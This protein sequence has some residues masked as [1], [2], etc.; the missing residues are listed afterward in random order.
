MGSVVSHCLGRVT[1]VLGAGIEAFGGASS[2]WEGLCQDL[3]Q[4]SSVRTTVTLS[5]YLLASHNG[6][7]KSV[8]VTPDGKHV[9]TGSKDKTARVWS[10][11]DGT[12]Q[13]ELTGHAMDAWVLLFVRA[14]CSRRRCDSQA[15]LSFLNQSDLLRVTRIVG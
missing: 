8:C 5:D 13:R 9:V 4:A 15:P 6:S 7:V 2:N 11:E 3:T 10:L 14:T 12:M 1:A